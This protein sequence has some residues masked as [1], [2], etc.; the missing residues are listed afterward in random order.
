VLPTFN[1]D[2]YLRESIDSCLSQ[3]FGNIEL[4]VVDDGSAPRV[5]AIAESYADSRLKYIRHETNRGLASAL[6][7]GFRHS[8]GDYLTWT[9]DD[10]R[11]EPTAVE[12]MLS[13]L[14]RY[15]EVD[16]VYA[17][18]IVFGDLDT[19]PRGRLGARP[20]SALAIANC[21]GACFLYRR[22]VYDRVGEFRS[23]VFLAEDYDYWIRVNQQ[24]RMQ[25]LARPL[26]HY[27]WHR[28]SL[29]SKHSAAEVAA[30]VELVKRLNRVGIQ[31]RS[32]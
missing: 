1:G 17:E 15:P 25:R 14:T 23:E 10:N 3:S 32:T 26:Y 31:P 29:T 24:C 8:T 9:S 19:M 22:A 27:R 4:L 5:R 6:N 11:Y 13:F 7:T 30:R 2:K 12:E 16:F 28:D 18:C 20:A 21:I